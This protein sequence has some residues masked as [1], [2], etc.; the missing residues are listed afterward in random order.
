MILFKIIVYFSFYNKPGAAA[1]YTGS[2]T[3]VLHPG[4][5]SGRWEFLLSDI[6]FPYLGAPSL[7]S[8][9]VREA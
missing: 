6:G 9:P 5:R 8:P 1:L 3:Q 2:R 4:C 7:F